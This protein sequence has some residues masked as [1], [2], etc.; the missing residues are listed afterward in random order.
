MAVLHQQ[1]GLFI[2]LFALGGVIWSGLA[3]RSRTASARL[4][5]LGWLTVALLGLQTVTGAI[6][7]AGGSRPGDATHFVFG[8][9]SLA[10]LP[11]ALVVRR[12]RPPQT[13]AM[14]MLAGWLLTF[15]LSL[16]A[17]GTGGLNAG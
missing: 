9:L 7:A 2:V 4:A 5:L 13:A 15:A 12:G 1:L 14:L 3:A 10:S 11:I 16:R 6:L 8:P 17:L